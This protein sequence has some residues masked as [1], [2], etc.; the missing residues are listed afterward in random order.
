VD[1]EANVEGD[2]GESDVE[3]S[4]SSAGATNAPNSESEPSNSGL[5]CPPSWRRLDEN[6][7]SSVREAGGVVGSKRVPNL[8]MFPGYCWVVICRVWI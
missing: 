1:G 2:K 5:G 4:G 6:V 3:P 7:V 8:Y